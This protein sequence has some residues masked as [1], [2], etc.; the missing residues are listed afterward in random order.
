MFSETHHPYESNTNEQIGKFI[1][2]TLKSNLSERGIGELNYSGLAIV[3]SW[4]LP[5]L[6]WI[7]G[8]SS[9][10]FCSWCLVDCGRACLVAT[11]CPRP[12]IGNAQEGTVAEQYNQYII[13]CNLTFFLINIPFYRNVNT[14]SWICNTICSL[15]IMLF[16]VHLLI[17][18]F[19]V[20]VLEMYFFS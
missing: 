14:I 18:I 7:L 12:P 13:I 19:V 5:T 2:K 15:T 11:G 9:R 20:F 4:G 1:E 8:S 10:F 17:I 3:P 16:F 6:L